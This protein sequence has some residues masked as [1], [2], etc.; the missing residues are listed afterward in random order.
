VAALELWGTVGHDVVTLEGQRLSV[1]SSESADLVIFDDPAVSRVH[2]VLERIGR[3]WCV[4]DLGSR[5]GTMVNNERLFG[6]RVLHDGAELVIGR[7]RLVFHDRG[8]AAVPVTEALGAP[9]ELTRRERDVLRELCRPV[10]SGNAFTQPASVH[11]IA[12][13]LCVSEAA[14]KQHLG[15]L[16]DKFGILDDE[17]GPR[18]VLLA[19]EALHRGA[20]N[21]ADMR[22][23]AAPG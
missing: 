23:E 19:N 12:D 13:A 2:F 18:R 11:D 1:G 9:P 8:D 5:N 15:R 7:T 14:V 20:L 6:D 16:Y 10:L 3:A 22:D 17:Q 21:I 4:R